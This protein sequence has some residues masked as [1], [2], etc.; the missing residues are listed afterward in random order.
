M[1]ISHYK[2]LNICI[3]VILFSIV[4]TCIALTRSG[5]TLINRI[6]FGGRNE[7]ANIGTGSATG[8]PVSEYSI[9]GSKSSIVVS[10]YIRDSFKHTKVTME[11]LLTEAQ[12]YFSLWKTFHFLYPL[13]H[14]IFIFIFHISIFDIFDFVSLVSQIFSFDVCKL[15]F[16]YK[17]H[18]L[19]IQNNLLQKSRLIKNNSPDWIFSLSN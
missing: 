11:Y 9:L 5:P 13:E 6:L 3:W 10:C 2:S 8:Y 17:L 15:F 19:E 4:N 18:Y 1:I 14:S 7:M 12:L 16:W